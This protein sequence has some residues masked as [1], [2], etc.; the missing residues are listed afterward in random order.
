MLRTRLMI[1]AVLAAAL[2]L[3]GV[4][5]AQVPAAVAFDL[6]YVNY[7]DNAHTTDAP[8]GTVRI[9]DTAFIDPPT[10]TCAMIY[11]FRPDQQLAECCGCKVTPN[12]L[13]TFSV[14]NDL[15]A[16]PLTSDAF[17]RGSLFIASASP[18]APPGTAPKGSST[19]CDPGGSFVE[20]A[21]LE[22]WV[23][24]PQ[25]FNAPGV[26]FLLTESHPGEENFDST[27]ATAL[28]NKCKGITTTTLGPGGSGH[29]LCTCPQESAPLV[30]DPPIIGTVSVPTVSTATP[31]ATT[32][33]VTAPSVT[34]PSVTPPSVTAP[35][36]PTL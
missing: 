5:R 3:P 1:L 19:E 4:A 31:T 20:G 22:V 17:T 14:N 2:A 8:D 10:D 16:N 28:A 26:P 35:S 9:V 36:A 32:S 15:T 12:G 34:V 27:E 21:R 7:F 23:T 29:G 6:Y 11:V 25:R 13:L 33:S 24:N 18:N 30:V